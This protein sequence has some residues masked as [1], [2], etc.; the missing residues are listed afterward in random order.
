MVAKKRTLAS[1]CDLR[2]SYLNG[3]LLNRDSSHIIS[4]GKPISTLLCLTVFQTSV[5]ATIFSGKNSSGY[6]LLRAST[7]F[8]RIIFLLK[9]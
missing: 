4:L 9:Y 6:E 7:L 8:S 2:F 1:S 3:N 5:Q